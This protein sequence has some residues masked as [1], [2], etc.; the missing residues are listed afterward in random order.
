MELCRRLS[1]AFKL[2]ILDMRL[3]EQINL[4]NDV[5]MLRSSES[6]HEKYHKF[7]EL[8]GLNDGSI[9]EPIH[10][11]KVVMERLRKVRM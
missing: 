3:G 8:F 2:I 5:I 9:S 6:F 4:D 10:C 1:E 7:F 11:G